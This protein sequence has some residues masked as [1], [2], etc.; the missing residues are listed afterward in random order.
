MVT[1]QLQ[2][3]LKVND[4]DYDC[5]ITEMYDEDSVYYVIGI[6]EP[7]ENQ[8]TLTNKVHAYIMKM[9]LNCETGHPNVY[10]YNVPEIPVYVKDLE[11]QIAD[12]LCKRNKE[13][14]GIAE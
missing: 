13:K 12:M 2:L 6:G 10:D 3:T 14:S 11:Q 4:T 8:I 7:V 5:A 1:E 9:K